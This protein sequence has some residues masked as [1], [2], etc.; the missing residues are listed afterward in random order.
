M[1]FRFPF[2]AVVLLGLCISGGAAAHP[3]P[4]AHVH[5][6]ARVEV[7]LDAGEL[8][9]DFI[10]PGA[11]VLGFQRRAR[12]DAEADAVAAIAA[13]IGSGDWIRPANAGG[14]RLSQ[15]QVDTAAFERSADAAVPHADLIA[16]LRYECD[17]PMALDAI[18]FDP[19]ARF[20]ALERLRVEFVTAD[21]QG[22]E[23]L[24]PARTRVQ[25]A[26]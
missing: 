16:A 18:V 10:A 14:C 23:V 11:S 8:A 22:S 5:G 26:P 20:P 2:A 17:R 6:E 4:G 9:I 7:S 3:A 13:Y 25:L 21:A 19:F 24:T 12:T 15:R 1:I